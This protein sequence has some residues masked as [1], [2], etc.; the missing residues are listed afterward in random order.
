M[1]DGRG[2]QRRLAG[3]RRRLQQ[4]LTA[5]RQG[6]LGQTQGEGLSELSSYDNH[7]GDLGTEMWKREQQVG[8]DQDLLRDLALVDEAEAALKQG[9]YGLCNR[10]GR[11]IPPARL[12]ARPEALACVDC[13]KTLEAEAAQLPARP[14]QEQPL[15]PLLAR[16]ERDRNC[17]VSPRL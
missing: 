13:Q 4:S 11:T 14:P 7:P 9:R 12:A 6:D 10:C 17:G 3:R 1:P 16:P 8:Y 15:A 5:L 2:A